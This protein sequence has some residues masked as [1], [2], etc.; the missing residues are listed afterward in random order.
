[1]SGTNKQ[2][3]VQAHGV[4]A[5]EKLERVRHLEKPIRRG[6]PGITERPSVV[7]SRSYIHWGWGLYLGPYV[8]LSSGSTLG[9]VVQVN[10][11]GEL[12]ALAA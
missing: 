7:V 2:G 6:N 3:W 8:N 5:A 1:M 9:V 12:L 4:K 11:S 10:A